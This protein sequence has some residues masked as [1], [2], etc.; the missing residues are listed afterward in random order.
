[1][2]PMQ[3]MP[4]TIRSLAPQAMPMQPQAMPMQPQAMQMQPQA[5]Q[6]QPQAMPMQPV[7]MGPPGMPM[8]QMRGVPSFSDLQSDLTSSYNARMDELKKPENSWMV[9]ILNI[10]LCLVLIC[11][12]Y[13]CIMAIINKNGYAAIS[14]QCTC[15]IILTLLLFSINKS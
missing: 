12:V 2:Q 4:P 11:C 6:M 7:M 8:F 13:S 5:M 10:I 15:V 14:S 3:S 9:T 1:M